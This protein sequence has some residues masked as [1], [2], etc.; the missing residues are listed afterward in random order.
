VRVLNV[1]LAGLGN[2]GFQVHGEVLRHME[3]VRLHAVTDPA[4][5]LREE[6]ERR[7]G[8]RACATFEE[9]LADP[10]IGVVTIATPHH[11]HRPMALQALAAGKHVLVEKAMCLD[12]AEAAEMFDAAR[13]AGRL[14]TVYQNWR[15]MPDARLVRDTILGGAL[16]RVRRIETRVLWLPYRSVGADG[17]MWGTPARRSWTAARTLGGGSLLMFGPHLID[18]LL[19]TLGFRPIEVAATAQSVVAEDDHVQAFFRDGDGVVAEVEMNLAAFVGNKGRWLVLGDEGTLFGGPDGIVVRRADD[20]EPRRL[21]APPKDER[22]T[23]FPT[24]SQLYRNL[25][26]AILDGAPLEVPPEQALALMR[27]LDAV[28]E[29]SRSG[30]PASLEPMGAR[31]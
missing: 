19:F 22:G 7:Y 1:G 4:P 14:L 21:E 6:A 30:R 29:A 23:F 16:G 11:L 8:C 27:R 20:P 5:R 18:Q 10:Q 25:R 17:R 31:R 2:A 15:H 3:D 12:A 9:L 28:R 13:A 26:D 24:G